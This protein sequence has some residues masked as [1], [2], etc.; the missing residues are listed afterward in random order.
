M[1]WLIQW[2]M[3][4]LVQLLGA[5]HHKGSTLFAEYGG[6][7]KLKEPDHCIV[8]IPYR[9]STCFGQIAEP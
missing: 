3:Q 5:F 9:F 1:Q 6:V 8:R 4:L 2:L 7:D